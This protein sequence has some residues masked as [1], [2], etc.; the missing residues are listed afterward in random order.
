MNAREWL[1]VLIA[2]RGAPQGLD[3]VRLQKGMFLFSQQAGRPGG[4][5]YSFEPYNYGPMSRA[6]YR[7]LDRLVESGHIERIPVTGYSW[8]R[9]LVTT[10]GATEAQRLLDDMAADE[11]PAA[12]RLFEIK[13]RVSSQSFAELLA[14]VYAEYPDYAVNSVF[15]RS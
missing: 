4:E 10:D 13:E 3:P 2:Y 6:M 12:R 9:H 1:L 8:Q 5:T 11:I 7:D 14:G 15:Q